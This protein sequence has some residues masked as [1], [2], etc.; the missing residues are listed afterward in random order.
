M[1]PITNLDEARAAYRAAYERD[2]EE[3]KRYV[4]ARVRRLS[5][6]LHHRDAIPPPPMVPIMPWYA[7]V[8][9]GFAI[10]AVLLLGGTA[11]WSYF[12]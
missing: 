7:Q 6:A 12:K 8:A 10:G 9:L 2:R 4:E 11:V 3:H 1:K 5:E